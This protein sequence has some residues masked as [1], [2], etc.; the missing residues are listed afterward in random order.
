MMKDPKQMC[1][2]NNKLGY[3]KGCKQCKTI[4]YKDKHIIR[5]LQFENGIGH[6]VEKEMHMY[7]EVCKV[8]NYGVSST[9]EEYEKRGTHEREILKSCANQYK[10]TYVKKSERG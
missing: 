6:W 2:T 9:K 1:E 5:M 10:N 4:V 7:N 8:C 3:R